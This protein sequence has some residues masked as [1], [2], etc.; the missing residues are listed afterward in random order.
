[1]AKR[2]PRDIALI[3]LFAA[4][5]IWNL[6]VVQ[7]IRA[8]GWGWDSHAYFL[9]ARHLNYS[10]LPNSVGAYLYAPAFAEILRPAAMLLP[11]PDFAALW[12]ISAALTLAF[13]LR[14]LSLPW[15]VAL[16][17]F[18]LWEVASGNVHWLIAVAVA[19]GF[20]RPAFWTIPMLTK[21]L[22]GL[23]IVW[24]AVRKEW[25]SLGEAILVPA[26]IVT[27]SYSVDPRPWHAWV[28]LLRESLRHPSGTAVSIDFPVWIRAAVSLIIIVYAARSS[29]PPLVAVAVC[30]ASP[31]WALAAVIV[32][33]AIPVLSNAPI[34]ST[35]ERSYILNPAGESGDSRTG[36]GG[37]HP[38]ED[39]DEAPGRVEDLFGHLVGREA[40]GDVPREGSDVPGD[41]YLPGN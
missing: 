39:V 38:R 34:P 35:A 28:A 11:W 29:R 32:L 4:G 5:V 22:P 37:S 41:Q 26:A 18:S 16:L 3:L 2:L 12:S 17:Y 31:N 13:L 9:A 8:Y 15:R 7:E 20:R 33:Y 30:L 36:D 21:A 6:L 14:P 27:F 40:P 25:R 23:G 19:M 10:S 1:M 24:F